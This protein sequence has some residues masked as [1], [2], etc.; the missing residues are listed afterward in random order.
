MQ[1]D[2]ESHSAEPLFIDK[3]NMTEV[4]TGK[5]SY[6]PTI[7]NEQIQKRFKSD[8]Q[9]PL[10]STP[11]QESEE[12]HL[13]EPTTPPKT[14]NLSH[15]H[16]YHSSPGGFIRRYNGMR[17]KLQ[18][19]KTTSK[20]QKQVIKRLR[21]KV[22]TLSDIVSELRRTRAVSENGLACLDS[23]AESDVSQLMKRF[24]R[25]NNVVKTQF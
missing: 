3:N 7:E 10:E 14:N 23:I 1:P 6:S 2:I 21:K 24:I 13:E 11:I 18:R 8:L 9:S 20:I 25:N 17:Q 19:C 22:S 5:R 12:T 15:D 16:H 4:L